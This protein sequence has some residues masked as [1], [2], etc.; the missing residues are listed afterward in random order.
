MNWRIFNLSCI[1]ESPGEFLKILVPGLGA[2]WETWVRSL[3]GEYPLEKG[4]AIHFSILAWRILL[5]LPGKSREFQ[6]SR[7]RGLAGALVQNPKQ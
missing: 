3:G 7:Q 4:M 1:L 5:W 6:A 2:K